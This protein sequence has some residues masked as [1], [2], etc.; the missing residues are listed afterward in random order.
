MSTFRLTIEDGHFRDQHGRQVLLRGIN[1]G[2]DAK[3]PSEPDQSSFIGDDFFD[4]D[5]VTFYQRPF[6]ASEAAEHFS[7]I[8]R[9]GFNAIRYIFT[10]EA[11]ESAGP[12]KY[13]EEWIRHTIEVLRVAKSFGFYVF[14][15]PHQDVVG[16]PGMLGAR[17]IGDRVRR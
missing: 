8:R 14:M 12:G 17:G 13:D 7:R 10:W 16:F 2:A 1:C 15:D 4:G 9:Y 11:V 6:P 3:F 5:G